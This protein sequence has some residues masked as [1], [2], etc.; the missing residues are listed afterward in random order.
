M[1]GEQHEGGS[2]GSPLFDANGLI[3]GTLTGGSSYCD[4]QTNPDYYGK[5]YYHIG[6]IRVL[7]PWNRLKDWLDPANTGVTTLNGKYCNGSTLKLQILLA[8]SAT[9]VYVG[10]PVTFTN[11]STGN[12]TSSSTCEFWQWEP[13]SPRYS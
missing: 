3:V 7:T 6:I 9:T 12:P 13:F 10:Q 2:S 1:D 5:M 8:C 4:A 11:T